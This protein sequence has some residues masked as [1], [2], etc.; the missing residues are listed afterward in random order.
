M[1]TDSRAHS[2]SKRTGNAGSSP[3]IK[4]PG[5][6]DT[7]LHLKLSLRKRAA[8]TEILHTVSWSTQ[9]KV[10]L[11]VDAMN[12]YQRSRCMA[13]FILIIGTRLELGSQLHEPAVLPH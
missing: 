1:H 9:V 13:P 8:T 7:H 2:V 10:V 6:E 11:P 4:R 12:E 5:R 3:E